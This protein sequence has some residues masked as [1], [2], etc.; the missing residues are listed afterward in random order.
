M[1]PYIQDQ[2][3]TFI[4]R[5]GLEIQE[6]GWLS[7]LLPSPAFSLCCVM[8]RSS[9][10]PNLC[11]CFLCIPVGVVWC[12][13]Y[14]F[15][16]SGC[17]TSVTRDGPPIKMGLKNICEATSK[18]IRNTHCTPDIPISP[19]Y[20]ETYHVISLLWRIAM[21]NTTIISSQHIARHG[22]RAS[23]AIGIRHALEVHQLGGAIAARGILRILLGGHTPAR[24]MVDLVDP[25]SLL[26]CI[27]V[28]YSA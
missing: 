20:I 18:I 5:S 4:I 7:G 28:I 15:F 9:V 11:R 22:M 23:N 14:I 25:L 26:V 8:L 10:A 24:W 1:V 27:T 13:L 2:P 17:A 19:L 16:R 12:S 6:D 21:A 3:K